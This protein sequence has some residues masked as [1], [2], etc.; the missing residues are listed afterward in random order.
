[1]TRSEEELDVRTVRRV[2]GRV[3]LRKY[4]VTEEVQRTIPVR[5][6]ELRI[7]EVP[8]SEEAAASADAGPVGGQQDSEEQEIVLQEEVPVIERRVR[9]RER[10]RIVKETRREEAP[11]VEEVRA[12]RIKAEG[13]LEH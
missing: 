5:R 7:E 11:V 8:E 13:D 2:R 10:V 3:R 4:V 12:E 9:P 1:M 6:E